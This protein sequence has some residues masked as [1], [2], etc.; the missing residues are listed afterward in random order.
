MPATPKL[1]TSARV[2]NCLTSLV[3]LMYWTYFYGHPLW[4]KIYVQGKTMAKSFDIKCDKV[5]KCKGRNLYSSYHWLI[6][7]V[8]NLA[9]SKCKQTHNLNFVRI[10]NN[11]GRIISL[12]TE[13]PTLKVWLTTK[14][15]LR[16]H[17]KDQKQKNIFWPKFG[18]WLVSLL[19][20]VKH[21]QFT[22]H[23]LYVIFF[24]STQL[25]SLALDMLIKSTNKI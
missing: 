2:F 19:W 13:W 20:F 12:N 24:Y 22:F 14:D 6:T 16:T 17:C 7:L 21:T 1:T 11:C 5:Q 15:T 23:N 9:F 25:F 10:T 8:L 3:S 4:I 18:Q